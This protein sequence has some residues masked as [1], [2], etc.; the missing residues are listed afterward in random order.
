LKRL[1]EQTTLGG[2]RPLK[3]SASMFKPP[4]QTRRYFLSWP[5]RLK[6]IVVV[7]ICPLPVRRNVG[8]RVPTISKGEHMPQKIFVNLPV[9]DLKKSMDFFG[10]LG[11]TFNAQFTDKTAACMVVSEDIYVMLLTQNKFQT[12]TPKTNLRCNQEH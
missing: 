5:T 10:K 1:I 3:I 7:S 2:E 12:F 4:L 8:D 9:R 6:I 11:F